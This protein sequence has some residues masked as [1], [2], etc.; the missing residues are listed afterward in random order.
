MIRRR[1][2]SIGRPNGA[3]SLNNLF[4]A[5]GPQVPR[6]AVHADELGEHLDH[7]PRAD[8]AG[9]VNRQAGALTVPF[10]ENHRA[11]A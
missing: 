11:L 3:E 5:R 2:S 10:E 1:G 7:A 6:G 8:A 9:H 4:I